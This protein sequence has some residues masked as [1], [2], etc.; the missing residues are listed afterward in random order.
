MA[1]EPAGPFG[2]SLG[3][4]D[5]APEYCECGVEFD[6]GIEP[7]VHGACPECRDSCECCVEC[8][9]CQKHVD[10]DEFDF[11]KDRCVDCSVK[12]MEADEERRERDEA[13]AE[14]KADGIRKYGR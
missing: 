10:A 9:T 12:A 6:D 2:W 4:F 13:M 14:D 8:E 1:T 11:D 7:C 5:D 3:L